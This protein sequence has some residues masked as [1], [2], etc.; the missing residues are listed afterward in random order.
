MLLIRDYHMST[1][2]LQ[3]I[4]ACSSIFARGP[5]GPRA[6]M[7]CRADMLG[8]ATVDMFKLF[9]TCLIIYVFILYFHDF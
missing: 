9:I 1:V 7:E 5:L 8:N 3:S 6:N 4:S 2:A